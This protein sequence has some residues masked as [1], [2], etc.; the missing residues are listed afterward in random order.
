MVSAS[1]ATEFLGKV[2]LFKQVDKSAL[3]HL[4]SRMKLVS[5]PAGPLVR[6]QEPGDS[7]YIIK[8]GLAKVAKVSVSGG[9]EAV[10]AVLKSGDSFGEIALLDGLPRT[11]DV[12]AMSQTQCYVLPRR[13]FVEVLDE[14]PEIARAMLPTL[15][16]MV[17]G[18]DRWI[19]S[20]ID[21]Q[22]SRLV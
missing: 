6:E 8:S 4:A 7:L 20:L 21:R 1:E 15:A 18:A 19:A 5:F 13:A 12:V 2:A 11:A 22:A 16:G 14:H 9:M 17:R 3:T 10:L